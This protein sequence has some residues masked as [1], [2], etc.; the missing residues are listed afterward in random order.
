MDPHQVLVNAQDALTAR[1]V[2]GDPIQADGATIIPVAK[3]GGGGGGGD[4][5]G[6]AGAGF[7]LTAKPAGVFVVSH[8]HVA[9]RPAL[10]VNRVILGGQLVAI[11][12]LLTLGPSLARWLTA[13][14]AHGASAL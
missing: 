2:F 13:R 4:R 8:G 11:T 12:A 6:E 3:L 7:G 1:R 14:R 9:W 5:G 10:D